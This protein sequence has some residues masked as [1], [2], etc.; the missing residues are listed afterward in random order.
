MRES[1][2]GRSTRPFRW[3]VPVRRVVLAVVRTATSLNRQMDVLSVLS[4]SEVAIKFT[5]DP[6]SQFSR[7][8]GRH[9]AEID[10]DVVPWE[11]ACA[12]RYD[13]IIAAHVDANLAQLAKTGE[14]LVVLAHGAGYNRLV[15]RST[16]SL[17]APAGLSPKELVHEGMVFPTVIGLSHEKQLAR[18]A[19][20]CP[21]AIPNAR[22]VG[23]PTFD[24]LRAS[25]RRREQYRAHLKVPADRCLLLASSTWNRH[26]LLGRHRKLIH[27]LVA[28]LPMDRY[29]IA[30]VLHHNIWAGH[31]EYELRSMLRDALDSGV[32][33]IQPTSWQGALLAADAVIG[34]HGSVSFYGAALG[35]PYLRASDGRAELDPTSP[36]AAFSAAA[37]P[38]DIDGNLGEQLEMARTAGQRLITITD[39]TLGR[40]DQSWN[41]LYHLCYELMCLDPPT[42]SVRM[43]PV[44]NPVPITGNDSTA[45]LICAA[46][47]GVASSGG[48]VELERYPAVVRDFRNQGDRTDLF[49]VVEDMEVDGPLR[50][51]ADI[52]FRAEVLSDRDAAGWTKQALDNNP[53]AAMVA[54]TTSEGCLLRWHSGQMWEAAVSG[55]AQP[56]ALVAAAAV[57]GWLVD[58]RS[59]TTKIWLGVRL[60]PAE[61][62]VIVRPVS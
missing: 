48:L 2:L 59:I 18:L 5:I 49:E 7:T 44:A 11:K 46:I 51:N 36:A 41:I 21:Q 42:P 3:T 43:L 45:W 32:L 40:P 50:Q 25:L 27:R 55:T 12:T 10:A 30:V 6:G 37:I 29:Q 20:S 28:R 16:G 22:V 62:T 58:F 14:P 1:D 34:D 9:L 61:T 4:N 60:G 31:S 38:L 47:H 17:R 54:A 26:S 35:L 56:P 24:R 8:L 33:I 57:Y 52:V 19:Q 23:D 13:L 39:Q 15:P 53:G